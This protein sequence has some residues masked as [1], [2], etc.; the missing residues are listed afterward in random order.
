MC[1]SA[2]P[3]YMQ[4]VSDT[5]EIA[6]ETVACHHVDDGSQTHESFVEVH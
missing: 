1:M 2:S 3:T 4:I 6:W 5:L